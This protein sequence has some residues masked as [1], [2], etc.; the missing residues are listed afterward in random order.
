MSRPSPSLIVLAIVAAAFVWSQVS[1]AGRQAD[2]EKAVADT[3][4]AVKANCEVVSVLLS[5]RPDRDE[6]IKLFDPIRRENPAQFDKLVKRAEDGD[7][8]L[9]VV[10]GDLACKPPAR[11]PARP[12]KRPH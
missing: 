4:K 1:A 9:A 3:A 6:A 5:N 8:R 11:R 7:R 12:S 10:Q 2:T